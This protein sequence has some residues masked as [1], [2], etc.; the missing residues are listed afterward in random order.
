[1]V[2]VDGFVCLVGWLRGKGVALTQTNPVT[3]K[4]ATFACEILE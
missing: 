2:A 3:I 4:I 1:L